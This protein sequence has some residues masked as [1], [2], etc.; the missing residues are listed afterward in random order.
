MIKDQAAGL[1]A[2]VAAG[3]PRDSLYVLDVLYDREGARRP[4]MIV[5]DTASYNDI[6]FRLLTLAESTYVPQLADPANQKMWR[7]DHATDCDA[8]QDA[9]RGRRSGADRAPL[10]GHPADR[11]H[12]GLAV[13]GRKDFPGRLIGGQQDQV[14]ASPA[15]PGWRVFGVRRV[16]TS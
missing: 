3:T 7:V 13:L 9:A 12:L 16:C 10:G 4:E 14:R 2:R 15:A 6:V 5:T 1:G 11:R 8:F